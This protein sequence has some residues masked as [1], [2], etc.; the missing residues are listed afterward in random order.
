MATYLCV[1]NSKNNE[2]KRYTGKENANSPYLKVNDA[3]FPLTT[4][5]DTNWGLRINSNNQIYRII[6]SYTTTLKTTENYTDYESTLETTEYYTT[7][8]FNS[9][10]DFYEN[11]HQS[12]NSE[13]SVTLPYFSVSN[14]YNGDII[15]CGKCSVDPRFNNNYG[16]I[17]ENLW[18]LS[19]NTYSHKFVSVTTFFTKETFTFKYSH[20]I[21]YTFTNSD[22]NYYTT[23]SD[24][25]FSSFYANN[26]TTVMESFTQTVATGFLYYGGAYN[27]YVLCED[28]A[29]ITM[30]T[31]FL[32]SYQ[33]EIINN[34]LTQR[35]TIS[36]SMENELTLPRDH[37][38]KEYQ[39]P[40]LFYGLLGRLYFY[41]AGTKSYT[42]TIKLSYGSYIS[43]SEKTVKATIDGSV[44]ITEDM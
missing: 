44:T 35:Y 4:E 27:K 7:R 17:R 39:D 37:S 10:K 31:S 15:L 41:V 32:T 38:Y 24:I 20:N 14:K 19:S 34:K 33:T 9:S 23:F 16:V 26:T 29:Y 22:P 11:T 36:R 42:N 5:T 40:L 21:S 1:S 6:E 12:A 8:F 3:Y 43:Q 13:I 28:Q 25:T 2:T 30:N 18:V